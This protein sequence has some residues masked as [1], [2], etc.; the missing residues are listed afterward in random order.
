MVHRDGAAIGYPCA[1]SFL[2]HAAKLEGKLGIATSPVPNAGIVMV[3]TVWETAMPGYGVPDVIAYIQGI[4]FFTDRFQ[5]AT[6]VCSD[7]FI[8]RM[9]QCIVDKEKK[10]D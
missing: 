10:I 3:I 5:T 2:A 7:L 1:I 6:N 9:I 8:L 4:D